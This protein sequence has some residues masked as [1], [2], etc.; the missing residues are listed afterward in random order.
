MLKPIFLPRLDGRPLAQSRYGRV[1]LR[2][3]HDE[4]NEKGD[5]EDHERQLHKAPPDQVE[6]I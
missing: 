1:D 3:R 2:K 6:H 5:P 4:E